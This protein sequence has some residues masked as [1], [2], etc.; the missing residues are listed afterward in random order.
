VRNA[1]RALK[2]AQEAS[3]KL[4]PLRDSAGRIMPTDHADE[5]Q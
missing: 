3:A 4:P 5:K 1:L 2:Q